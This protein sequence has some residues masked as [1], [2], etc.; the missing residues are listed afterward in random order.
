[1]ALITLTPEQVV[2]LRRGF[3]LGAPT[4]ADFRGETPPVP[5]E[6]VDRL[7]DALR[8]AYTD[9]PRLAYE[10]THEEAAVLQSC[11]IVGAEGCDDIS[12]TDYEVVYQILERA[13]KE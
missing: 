10:W 6:V 13:I 3:D 5:F 4:P 1:M 9:H 2:T 11:F 8:D 7:S 12:D